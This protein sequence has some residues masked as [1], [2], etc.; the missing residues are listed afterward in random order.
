MSTLFYLS[1][2]PLTLDSYPNSIC[3]TNTETQ[4]HYVI[5]LQT[6]DSSSC[7]FS[8]KVFQS[9]FYTQMINISEIYQLYLGL[10]AQTEPCLRN[11]LSIVEIAIELNEFRNP[12]TVRFYS[13]SVTP[14]L[15]TSYALK[16]MS[17]DEMVKLNYLNDK[18]IS[19]LREEISNVKKSSLIYVESYKK[20]ESLC[21]KLKSITD[22]QQ[23]KLSEIDKY[24]FN[25]ESNYSALFEATLNISHLKKSADIVQANAKDIMTK[26]ETRNCW[27]KETREKIVQLIQ[28]SDSHQ[29]LIPTYREIEDIRYNCDLMLEN[30]TKRSSELEIK[31]SNF[32]RDFDTLRQA[33]DSS[34]NEIKKKLNIVKELDNWIPPFEPSI[35]ESDYLLQIYALKKSMRACALINSFEYAVGCD[36]GSIDCRNTVTHQITRNLKKEHTNHISAML[37]IGDRL[38]SGSYDF[39]IKLWDMSDNYEESIATFL[40]HK[41]NIHCLAHV[42]GVII[43]SGSSDN[44]IKLW[45]IDSRK[46][47]ITLLGHINTV[48]GILMLNNKTL[49]SVGLDSTIRQW[50][51]FDIPK[52][53]ELVKKRITDSN[54]GIS[55][56]LRLNNSTIVVGNGSGNL[57][58]WDLSVENGQLTHS[59]IE[60]TGYAYQIIKLS[61]NL[62]ASCSYDRSI[63]I[64]DIESKSLIKKLKGHN[65]NVYG[66]IRLSKS[67]LMSVSFD[68]SIVVWGSESQIAN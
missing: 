57:N 33:I 3:L 11:L 32:S 45:D 30:W 24:S 13:K 56:V 12:V 2:F 26:I 28:K 1:N 14:N 64:W 20:L 23:Q 16:W 47:V 67:Q 40:E 44:S 35:F 25:W 8:V 59:F 18:V 39:S 43:A 52:S 66:L 50:S 68:Q 6:V 42:R 22:L 49:L 29:D 62:I 5:S 15:I 65:S 36:D 37:V 27:F 7:F 21:S 60:H 63:C 54:G 55:C 53:Y 31:I 61:S 48:Y 9:Y 34:P 46:C 51:V 58:I 10:I 38:L 19:A 4:S 41:G 17:Q